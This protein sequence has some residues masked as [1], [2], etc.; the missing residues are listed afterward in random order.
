MLSGRRKYIGFYQV[1]PPVSGPSN[2]FS[3]SLGS[4]P[5]PTFQIESPSTEIEGCFFL[6]PTSGFALRLKPRENVTS[7][8]SEPL[9]SLNLAEK[10]YLWISLVLSVTSGAEGSWCHPNSSGGE[11]GND[12]AEV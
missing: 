1:A 2:L 10:K 11:R 5:V 7:S 4:F 9:L 12:G 6:E 8:P 3:V